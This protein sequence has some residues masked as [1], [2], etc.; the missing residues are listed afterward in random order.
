MV[1]WRVQVYIYIYIYTPKCSVRKHRVFR[2]QVKNKTNFKTTGSGSSCSGCSMKLHQETWPGDQNMNIKEKTC[3]QQTDLCSHHLFFGASSD[4]TPTTTS[5]S[6]APAV[7]PHRR[8][9]RAPLR[10]RGRTLLGAAGVTGATGW[11][12][13]WHVGRSIRKSEQ[14]SGSGG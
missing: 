3:S 14:P 11:A 13:V 6:L 8:G 10:C 5:P 4:R 1:L 2:D 9:A 7:G 12:A